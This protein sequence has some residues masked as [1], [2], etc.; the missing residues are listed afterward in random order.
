M[1]LDHIDRAILRLL[2]Q[3]HGW[4]N[5]NQI[6][7]KVDIAWLTAEKHLKQLNIHG[8]VIRGS[9]G[10]MIYWRINR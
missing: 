8:Y 10:S 7:D 3:Y 5:T 4:L 2:I 6:A 9:R 1:N